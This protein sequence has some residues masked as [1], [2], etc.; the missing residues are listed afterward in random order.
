MMAL[1]V[2]VNAIYNAGSMLIKYK[3]L[4]IRKELAEKHKTQAGATD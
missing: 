4:Q 1:Y 3:R 2:T